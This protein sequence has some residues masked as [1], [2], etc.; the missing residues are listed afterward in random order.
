MVRE[1]LLK[2]HHLSDQVHPVEV[3]P[4]EPETTAAEHEVMLRKHFENQ[5]AGMDLILLG[6]GDDATPLPYFRNE[7]SRRGAE[8]VRSQLG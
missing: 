2:N 8:M 4:S 5:T 6:L 3:N 1:T 7:S